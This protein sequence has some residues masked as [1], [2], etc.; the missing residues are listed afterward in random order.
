[1]NGLRRYSRPRSKVTTFLRNGA[2]V[3]IKKGIYIFG[4]RYRRRPFSREALANLLYGP[5]CLSLDYALQYHGLIPEGVESVTS[6]T[7][8]RSRR[9]E[10]P[11]GVFSYRHVPVKV[12]SAGVD[13]LEPEAGR[14]FLMAT[15]EK[16]LADK[17]TQAQGAPMRSQKDAGEYLLNN[18][19]ADPARLRELNVQKL[20][21]YAT[22]YRSGKIRMAGR[23]LARAKK[24]KG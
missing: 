18:L 13:R 5:S 15:P 14:A 4:E 19:R 16:A 21:N 22:L 8:G 12:Y 2:L 17:L 20:E 6:V 7:P 24:G 11:V 23:F 9:F 10:T 1:M 3:R